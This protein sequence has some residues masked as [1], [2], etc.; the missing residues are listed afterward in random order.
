MI[1]GTI[2]I[3]KKLIFHFLIEM[4]LAPVSMVYAFRNSF[5]LQENALML[6]TSTTET[7][8]LASKLSL[9]HTRAYDHAATVT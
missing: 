8:F 2:L 3:L 4:I 6:M 9:G 1:S 5:V 7:H